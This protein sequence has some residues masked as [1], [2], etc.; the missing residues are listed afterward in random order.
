M[1]RILDNNDVNILNEIAQFI[2]NLDLQ[3]VPVSEMQY[4]QKL[5]EDISNGRISNQS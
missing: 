2:Y 3:T 1:S 4:L 5:A